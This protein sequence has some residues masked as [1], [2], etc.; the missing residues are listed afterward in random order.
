MNTEDLTIQDDPKSKKKFMFLSK[1]VSMVKG[2]HDFALKLALTVMANSVL[3]SRLNQDD[4]SKEMLAF[5]KSQLEFMR[6]QYKAAQAAEREAAKTVTSFRDNINR[7]TRQLADWETP[8]RTNRILAEFHD[9]VV[10]ISPKKTTLHQGHKDDMPFGIL[11]KPLSRSNSPWEK[12]NIVTGE[13]SPKTPKIDN[14]RKL[15]ANE[16]REDDSRTPDKTFKIGSCKNDYPKASV[17]DVGSLTCFTSNNIAS[18]AIKD[19]DPK[20][21]VDDHGFLDFTSSTTA[22]KPSTDSKHGVPESQLILPDDTDEIFK[23]MSI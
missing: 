17:S 21:K 2:D 5:I 7:I 19:C 20:P 4:T 18:S 12:R 16:L 9:Q 11:A 1:F 23:D 8:K 14:K 10:N 13:S 22:T 3:A 15:P 6:V